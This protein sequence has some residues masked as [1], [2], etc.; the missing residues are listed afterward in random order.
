M[1]Q[2]GESNVDL[3]NVQTAGKILSRDLND[4]LLQHV[5]SRTVGRVR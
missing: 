3:W 1:N 2:F 5:E 4:E